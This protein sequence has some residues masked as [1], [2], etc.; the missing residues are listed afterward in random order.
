MRYIKEKI[1]DKTI[2]FLST[3][4]LQEL[5]QAVEVFKIAFLKSMMPILQPIC[6]LFNL[7]VKKEFL[8]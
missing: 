4:E 7:S 2:D 3:E 8:E 6:K 5:G 1:I